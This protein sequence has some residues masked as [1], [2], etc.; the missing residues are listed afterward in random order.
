MT[1]KEQNV[2][3]LKLTTEKENVAAS[4]LKIK[5]PEVDETNTQCNLKLA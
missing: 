2:I 5:K 3:A 1:I 4:E